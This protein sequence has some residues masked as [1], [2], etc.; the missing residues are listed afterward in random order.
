MPCNRDGGGISLF[1]SS[2]INVNDDVMFFGNKGISGRGGAAFVAGGQL[3]FNKISNLIENRAMSGGAVA[4]LST[5]YFKDIGGAN[6]NASI[7]R[8]NS[9]TQTIGGAFMG[10]GATSLPRH[11]FAINS[12]P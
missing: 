9:A 3:L 12:D 11:K 5:V 6:R 10:E 8:G 4:F 2:T 1:S 7:V